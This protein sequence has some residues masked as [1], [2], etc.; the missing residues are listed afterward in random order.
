MILE[1]SSP[2]RHLLRCQL[3]R[4]RKREI[5]GL[6]MGEQVTTAHFRILDI[7]CDTSS[8]ST[9]SFQRVDPL[10]NKA[11]QNFFDRTNHDYARYN[12]LGEWHSH[13]SFAVHPSATDI[14]SMIDLVQRSP[15]LEFAFL[16]IVKLSLFRLLHTK[17][18]FFQTGEYIPLR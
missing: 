4:A 10:H 15:D 13:P 2:V 3:W 14:D 18:V 11:L 7:S 5:G 8:G 12:Y 6:L 1:L 17:H 16:L 9:A